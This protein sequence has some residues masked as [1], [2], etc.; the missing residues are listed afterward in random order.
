MTGLTPGIVAPNPRVYWDDRELAPRG[1]QAPL[2]YADGRAGVDTSTLAATA[3]THGW[4][5]PWGDTR[6]MENWTYY[7]AQ[8]GDETLIPAA[9]QPGLS[10]DKESELDDTNTNGFADVGES[11]TYTFMVS[12]TGNSTIEDVTVD[13]SLVSGVTPAPV[14]L[15]VFGQ[16]LFTSAPYI[17]TQG[18]CRCRRRAQHRDR[19]GSSTLTTTRSSRRRTASSCRRPE[20]DPELTLDKVATLNDTNNNTVADLGETIDYTFLATNTGNV[21]LTDVSVTDDRVTGMSAPVTLA[22][23]ASH[24]FTSDAYTVVQADLNVGVVHNSAVADGSSALGAVDLEH[25]HGR[26]ADPGARPAASRSRSRVRSRPT[27]TA[28]DSLTSATR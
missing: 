17:V 18:G 25:R 12:N 11:I 13:D 6:S 21:T 15:P 9:C 1:A 27:S 2:P 22:P 24:E 3:G 20:R 26:S 19:D 10:I 8:A 16:Q 4:T 28:M 14:D 5:T 23:G 7:E